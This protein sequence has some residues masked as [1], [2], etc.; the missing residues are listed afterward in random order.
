MKNNK[1]RLFDVMSRLDKTFKLNEGIDSQSISLDVYVI[2]LNNKTLDIDSI[3]SELENL[4]VTLGGNGIEEVVDD[5][6]YVDDNYEDTIALYIDMNNNDTKTII[7][8]TKNKVFLVSTLNDFIQNQGNE[9]DEEKNFAS[10]L[11]DIYDE[12]L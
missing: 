7:Y 6:E 2:D 3:E 8:D 12:N 11:G 1:Q 4:N 9:I 10:E 5:T